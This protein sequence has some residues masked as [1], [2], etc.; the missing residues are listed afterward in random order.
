MA[1]LR[2]RAQ[3]VQVERFFCLLEADGE[4]SKSHGLSRAH[5]AA[6]IAALGGEPHWVV[7][8]PGGFV[9]TY[10]AHLRALRE[11][12]M[13]AMVFGDIDLRAHREWIA[14][15]CAAAGLQALFPL[16]DVPR[17]AVADEVLARGLQA[18]VVCV[19]GQ[20][21]DASFSGRAYDRQF[22]TDLPADVC[23]AGEDGEFHSFVWGG[24]G[25]AAPLKLR[26]GA[27]RREA[28]EPPLRP[29]ELV[30]CVPE[31]LE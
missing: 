1:L 17:Q 25:F 27:P 24:P 4:R 11:L 18:L 9:E 15:R 30:F 6:Q 13:D 14:P 2:A 28:S 7:V 23:P 31:L 22:L 10:D 21:L 12:G 3:G 19:D 20:R 26:P 5:L 16:W 8:P 29:T